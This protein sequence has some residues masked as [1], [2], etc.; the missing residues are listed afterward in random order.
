MRT[1][2]PGGWYLLFFCR[3]C[4][5]KQV[6]FPDLT[7]GKSTLMA[8]Y[9]IACQKCHHKASYDG[10]QIERYRHP[11]TARRAVA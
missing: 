10:E 9:I 2:T 3:G 5:T 6:L 4:K 11:E 7:Q 8:T 1:L